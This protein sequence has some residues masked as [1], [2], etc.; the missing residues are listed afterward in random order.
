MNNAFV[1][2]LDGVLIDS[3]EIHFDA[4]NLA[5]SEIDS[6]YVISK[7]DQ[8][9]TFEGLSTKAKLDILSYSKGLPKELHNV[10]WEKKQIYSAE[11]FKVFDK[12]QELINIFK[13]IKSF[14]IKIGVAS[15]AIRETVLES[16]KSLGIYDL[17]DYAL[18]NEDVSNPKPNPEIYKLMISLLGSSPEKTV[19]FEDSEIGQAAARASMAKLF[20]VT[21]RKDISLPYVD[22]K[23]VV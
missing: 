10:I 7:K 11:M 12:D 8:A 20:P 3:K 23:S 6:H 4:L 19:I 5:L 21:K 2:D 9:S 14:S 1:F 13:L 15:N 17:V 22:R 16:L 18:S